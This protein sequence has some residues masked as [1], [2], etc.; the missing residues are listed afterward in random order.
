MHHPAQRYNNGV[1]RLIFANNDIIHAE[2]APRVGPTGNRRYMF[3]TWN[4]VSRYVDIGLM[5]VAFAIAMLSP[6]ILFV[7]VP[8][9]AEQFDPMV[10]TS[11]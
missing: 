9:F 7:I 2:E 5:L 6:I 11:L 4:D 10:A 3:N 8:I 1:G